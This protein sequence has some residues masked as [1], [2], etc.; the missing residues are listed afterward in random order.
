MQAKA[1][2]P[3]ATK[4]RLVSL[5][6]ERSKNELTFFL[7]TVEAGTKFL[8]DD[9]PPRP[10][11]STI[12]RNIHKKAEDMRHGFLPVRPGATQLHHTIDAQWKLDSRC[13]LAAELKDAA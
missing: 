13:E 4:S 8:T 5:S 6:A 1:E 3:R 11:L 9:Q 7:H 2:E 12:R 10:I